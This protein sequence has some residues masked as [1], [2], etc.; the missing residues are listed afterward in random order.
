MKA[1][2]SLLALLLFI[3]S[4]PSLFAVPAVPWPIEKQ[5]PDGTIITVYLKGDEK[6]HWMESPDGYTLLYNDNHQVVYAQL[7]E[8]ENLVPS[9]IIYLPS[10]LRSS[11]QEL[12]DA[13]IKKGLHYSAEQV[14]LKQEIWKVEDSMLRSGIQKAPVTGAKKGLVILAEFTD[15]KFSKTQEQFN[16]LMN[17][18]GYSLNEAKG[19]VRDYYKEVSYGKLDFTVTVVGPYQV[20]NTARHYGSNDAELRPFALEVVMAADKD[21]NFKDFANENNEVDNFHIIYAGYGDEAFGDNDSQ[22]GKQIWAHAWVLPGR[23]PTV[24]DG[25]GLYSYSCSPELRGKS[26]KDITHIGVVCH[27]LCHAF[28]APDYYDADLD[29]S[30]GDFDGTGY[31]DLMASGSWNGSGTT[32]AHINMYQKIRFGWVDPDTLSSYR[33]VSGMP[34]SAKNPVAYLIETPAENDYYIL[35]NR[36]KVGF[37][38]NVPGSGLVIY[39]ANV[40]END[41]YYNTVNNGHPQKLYVVDAFS[42]SQYPTGTVESYGDIYGSSYTFKGTRSSFTDSTTPAAFYWSTDTIGKIGG[43]LGKPITNI[44]ESN[45]L[46]SFSFMK[47]TLLLS[48]V[49]EGTSL[50]LNW[51]VLDTSKPIKA[52]NVYLDGKFVQNTTNKFFRRPITL[53]RVYTCGVSALFQDDTESLIETLVVDATGSSLENVEKAGAYI[54]PNP[55]TAGS[56]FVVEQEELSAEP[57]IL[58]IYDLTGRLIQQ[59]E[60]TSVRHNVRNDLQPGT[61]L[62]QVNKNA[63]KDTF[64]LIVK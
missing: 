39:H 20:S 44:K 61:Y 18:E 46:I 29:G 8:E 64:K 28:G 5:Q 21:V 43:S 63:G 33:E 2:F 41:I 10:Q 12:A 32:P 52:Y 54:Y 49:L 14:R 25:V 60:V 58:T 26:G 37:D 35:E 45:Q 27:E 4:I 51:E 48:H 42:K 16:N 23:T 19:S 56:D 6:L 50:T 9:S 59:E 62:I 11:N 30:G 55:L 13:G 53:G 47:P 15:V 1:R 24:L 36:Q 57:V 31:W 3:C 38:S 22:S 34:N 17:Q 7:D 40:S